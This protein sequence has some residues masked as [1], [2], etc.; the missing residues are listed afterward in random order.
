MATE[1]AIFVHPRS[2]Y[3]GLS[4]D[5][6]DSLLAEVMTAPQIADLLQL[7]VS[8]IE[9]YARRRVLPS[10]KLG[11]H[12]RFIRSEV[13]DAIAD[14]SEEPVRGPSSRRK[15]RPRGSSDGTT[16]AASENDLPGLRI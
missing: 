14:L 16:S 4:S 1:T 13:E 6:G 11:R 5:V 12:R 2:D 3:A 10:L 8:T 7:P 15:S 9:D